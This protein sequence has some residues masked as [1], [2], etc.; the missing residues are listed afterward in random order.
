MLAM[1]PFYVQIS[2]LYLFWMHWKRI[3]YLFLTSSSTFQVLP[4]MLECVRIHVDNGINHL[5]C[6]YRMPL[7]TRI[8]MN[9]CVWANWSGLKL[10]F[11]SANGLDTW[12]Y[13][14]I[15]SIIYYAILHIIYI[16]CFFLSHQSLYLVFGRNDC[17]FY[18]FW[19]SSLVCIVQCRHYYSGCILLCW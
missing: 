14:R 17:L 6:T 13:Y 9:N 15:Q 7:M 8:W 12:T 3:Y 4:R 10:C 5:N 16:P 18:F 2:S 1:L 11:F 19:H